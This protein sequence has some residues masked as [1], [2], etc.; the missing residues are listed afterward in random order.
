MAAF[1]LMRGQLAVLRERG[2]DVTVI[3]SPCWE[4]DAAASRE[5]VSTISIPMEREITP[6]RDLVAVCRLVRAIRQIQPDIVNAGTPK[7]GLLGMIAARI[8]SVPARVYVLRGLR[9]ETTFGLKR[10]LLKITDRIASKCAHQVICVSDSIRRVYVDQNLAPAWKCIVVGPGSSNG[11]DVSRFEK[12]DARLKSARAIRHRFG[13]SP[14]SPVIGFVGRLT[15]DKG[16][17]ELAEAFR[18]VQQS[19]PNARLLLVGEFESGDP[20]PQDTVNWLRDNAAVSVAGFA[21]DPSDYYSA[22]DLLA[23]PSYREG[24]PNVPLEA[25]AAGIPVVGF[26][27]TGTVDAVLNGLTGKLVS[28]GD[29]AAL[30]EALVEYLSNDVLRYQHGQAGLRRACETFRNKAVWDALYRLYVSMLPEHRRP[31]FE[32]D[33][34]FIKRVA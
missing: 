25:A 17:V 2:F 3:A 8:A 9:L 12:T 24:F 10:L 20:V 28:T 15:R 30:A 27:A 21:K 19:H 7:A 5:G 31:V 29:T 32:S 16:I 18:I 26:A 6:F 14:D 4:L 13:I 34:S 1:S 33:D 22:M 23:F 11:I